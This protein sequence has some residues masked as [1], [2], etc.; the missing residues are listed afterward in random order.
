MDNRITQ[1][2]QYLDEVFDDESLNSA[3]KLMLIVRYNLIQTRGIKPSD[4]LLMASMGTSR[5]TYYRTKK[6]LKQRGIL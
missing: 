3:Q 4:E 5:A 6:S 1:H 2:N